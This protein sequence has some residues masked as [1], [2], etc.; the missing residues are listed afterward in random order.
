MRKI[1]YGQL[2]VQ[3]NGAFITC[4]NCSPWNHYSATRGDYFLRDPR[5]VVTCGDCGEPMQLVREERR[6]VEV[7]P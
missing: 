3:P 5:A 4:M 6:L 7:R 1:R 2:P